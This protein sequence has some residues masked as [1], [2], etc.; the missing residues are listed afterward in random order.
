MLLK[1]GMFARVTLPVGVTENAMLVPKDALVLG[2]DKPQVFVLQR[3]GAANEEGKVRAV[4]VTLGVAMGE[5]IQVRGEIEQ[6]QFVVVE[7]NERLKGGELVSATVRPE[8]GVVKKSNPVQPASEP[9]T[10]SAKGGAGNP[11]G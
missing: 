6:G 4:P 9:A 5:R 10:E 7:G 11:S 1:A 3:S 2:G 8:R